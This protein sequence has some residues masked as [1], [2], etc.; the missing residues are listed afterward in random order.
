[1]ALATGTAKYVVCYRALNGRSGQR[2]SQG[3]SGDI[4]T[5]DLIHWSWYMPWGG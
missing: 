5:S 1:M 3:V 4:V 2:Y